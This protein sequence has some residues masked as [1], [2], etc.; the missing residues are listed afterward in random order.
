MVGAVAR[1]PASG[2][3]FGRARPN[4]GTTWGADRPVA[5]SRF[6]TCRAPT[7]EEVAAR[8]AADDLLDARPP[9]AVARLEKIFFVG[10][11]AVLLARISTL[12]A[13]AA[14]ALLTTARAEWAGAVPILFSGAAGR[15]A[16]TGADFRLCAARPAAGRPANQPRH[17]S[18]AP[19]ATRSRATAAARAM[20][21]QAAP[22][23]LRGGRR[24]SSSSR[25]HS[26]RAGG[27]A[28]PSSRARNS[29]SRRSAPAVLARRFHRAGSG[30]VAWP[31]SSSRNKSS[32]SS[33]GGM[34]IA[35][36]G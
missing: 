35:V 2:S 18:P 14:G 10:T 6:A 21:H 32:I 28:W 29:S 13:V 15:G 33:S 11:E 30:G 36:V 1:A 22:R 3:A 31:A 5:T 9:A 16:T 7:G 4:A 8:L 17:S 27:V 23:R 12:G 24:C 34:A 25:S 20:G 26:S 19:P